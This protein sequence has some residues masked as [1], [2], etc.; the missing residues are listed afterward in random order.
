MIYSRRLSRFKVQKLASFARLPACR[1]TRQ[2][3]R[4][5]DAFRAHLFVPNQI[6]TSTHRRKPETPT[7]SSQS[8]KLFVVV[9]ATKP[10]AAG[11]RVAVVV[12]AGRGGHMTTSSATT[13]PPEINRMSRFMWQQFTH[14]SRHCCCC[15]CCRCRSVRLVS[16]FALAMGARTRRE[17]EGRHTATK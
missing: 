16:L 12:D 2:C 14:K 7:I 13:R 5:T 8:I 11:G 9:V 3:D 1:P 15:C 4:H 17:R 10:E 6:N